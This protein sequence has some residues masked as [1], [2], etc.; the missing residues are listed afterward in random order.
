MRAV[1]GPVPVV[2]IPAGP[3]EDAPA[4]PEA[5]PPAAPVLAAVHVLAGSQ[6]VLQVL[7][8]VPCTQSSTLQC[9]TP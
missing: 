6:A 5:A 2:R 7:R 9:S 3:G 4:V 8:P 1:L